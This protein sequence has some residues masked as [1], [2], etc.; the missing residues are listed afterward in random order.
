MDH[1]LTE[2][3]RSDKMVETVFFRHL[4]VPTSLDSLCWLAVKV[5]VCPGAGHMRMRFTI[6]TR[7]S[8]KDNTKYEVRVFGGCEMRWFYFALPSCEQVLFEAKAVF[9]EWR[10]R[11]MFAC[12]PMTSAITF[13]KSYPTRK[14]EASVRKVEDYLSCRWWLPHKGPAKRFL[15][16][17]EAVWH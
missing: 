11:F 6:S 12:S 2:K 4:K 1:R 13:P 14:P 8:A 17:R 3:G 5:L 15:E 10:T 7:T 16:V 9:E